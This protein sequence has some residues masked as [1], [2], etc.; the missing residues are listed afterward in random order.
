MGDLRIL[1]VNQCESIGDDGVEEVIK[2]CPYIQELY[3]GETRI[4]DTSLN[5][6]A[7]K[8]VLL[9]HLHIPGCENVTEIG[10]NKVIR[11]CRT[12]RHLDC[13]DCFNVV[14]QLERIQGDHEEE[15]EEGV[16]QVLGGEEEDEWTDL[17]D[18]SDDEREVP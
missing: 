8:L 16:V 6:L 9:T 13:R 12:L 2:N 7:T 14:G 5:S 18:D 4:T 11:E 15:E 3:L 17:E 1:S 10:I